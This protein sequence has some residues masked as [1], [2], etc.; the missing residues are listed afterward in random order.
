MPTRSADK[1]AAD[2]EEIAKTLLLLLIMPTRVIGDRLGGAWDAEPEYANDARAEPSSKQ[3]LDGRVGDIKGWATFPLK[4]RCG[5]ATE[6]TNGGRET[7][8]AS[9]E[10][11]KEPDPSMRLTPYPRNC[12]LSTVTG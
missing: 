12:G 7:A 11:E 1:S 4:G 8:P 6:S 3:T 5:S 10:F 2:F 9:E